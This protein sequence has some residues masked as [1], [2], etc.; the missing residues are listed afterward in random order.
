MQNT[1]DANVEENDEIYSSNS[2]NCEI[3][4]TEN[5]IDKSI[6]INNDNRKLLHSK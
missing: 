1:R 6:D 4:H 3:V 2:V 5:Y